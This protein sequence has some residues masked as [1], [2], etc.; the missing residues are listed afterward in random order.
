VIVSPQRGQFRY[1]PPAPRSDVR[2]PLT[3]QTG[4]LERHV[5]DRQ[6]MSGSARWMRTS[7]RQ[8]P[9]RGGHC[10][11]NA[12][13]HRRL[14][15]RGRELI[16]LDLGP[17]PC[18]EHP[19]TSVCNSKYSTIGPKDQP[20]PTFV[21]TVVEAELAQRLLDEDVVAQSQRW[22][23]SRAPGV[24]RLRRYS[25]AVPLRP[26]LRGDTGSCRITHPRPHAMA[27]VPGADEHGPVGAS[28]QPA[29][30]AAWRIHKGTRCEHSSVD[31]DDCVGAI[32]IV[33]RWSP[34][35][36]D[37]AAG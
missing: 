12:P 7:A 11:C 25:T 15:R 4:C 33:R 21:Q 32:A 8:L 27:V 6:P 20:P 9:R 36:V 30:R 10:D 26:P 3:T 2:P 28:R 35:Y 23:Q 34:S 24:L 16:L 14:G 19:P 22:R 5:D 37:R 31:L 17:V 13:T 1:Q 18:H 29:A